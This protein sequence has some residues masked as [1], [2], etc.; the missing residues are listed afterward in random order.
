LI[1]ASGLDMGGQR[2]GHLHSAYI[3]AL[4][5][6]GAVGAGLLALLLILLIRE[7]VAAWRNR[8]VSDAMFWAVTGCIGIVL[9]ANGFDSLMWRYDYSRAPLEV[10]FGSCLAYG[11]IRRRAA[12]PPPWPST[13]AAG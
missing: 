5:G 10:L 11:L 12:A 1:A 3:D 8:I 2:H 4:V 9:I 13:V 6:M 7:L